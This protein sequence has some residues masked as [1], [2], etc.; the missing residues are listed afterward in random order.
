MYAIV[1]QALKKAKPEQH[2][3]NPAVYRAAISEWN[4][5]VSIVA[6][7]LAETCPEFSKE[8][9]YFETTYWSRAYAW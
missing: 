5:T 4:T 3:G 1:A 9:F 8:K 2:V 6:N 7:S